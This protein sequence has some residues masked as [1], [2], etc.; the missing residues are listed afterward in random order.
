MIRELEL[1]IEQLLENISLEHRDLLK[2]SLYKAI[3]T[4]EIAHLYIS[5]TIRSPDFKIIIDTA[6]K[7]PSAIAAYVS[8]SN[9][10]IIFK[11]AN[12]WKVADSSDVSR[13]LLHEFAHG[14]FAVLHAPGG[15]PH[16][17]R[18]DE[19]TLLARPLAPLGKRKPVYNEL[20]QALNYDLQVLVKTL[21][22]FLTDRANFDKQHPELSEY[23]EELSERYVPKTETRASSE[24]QPGENCETK[25]EDVLKELK[26]FG[27]ATQI[28][29]GY[30]WIVKSLYEPRS[31]SCGFLD[32][33]GDTKWDIVTRKLFEL[34]WYITSELLS[35]NRF[36][37]YRSQ[38]LNWYIQDDPLRYQSFRNEIQL[39]AAELGFG[40]WMARIS[41]IGPFLQ[42]LQRT[43]RMLA[44][45]Y[46]THARAENFRREAFNDAINLSPRIREGYLK[47]AA[48]EYPAKTPEEIIKEIYKHQKM[49]KTLS[50]DVLEPDSARGMQQFIE[51]AN[52]KQINFCA[53]FYALCMA[54]N[55]FLSVGQLL[56]DTFIPLA[57]ETENDPVIASNSALEEN[58][59]WNT[60]QI[61]L[62]TGAVALS[63]VCTYLF[64]NRKNAN[65]T[66]Q[67]DPINPKMRRQ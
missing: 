16:K 50:L 39:A 40:E 14:Y 53:R 42:L 38:Y 33:V 62:T 31:G 65:D 63:L 29:G 47:V 25:Y 34:Y 44:T 32:H 24:L 11:N 46:E 3:S 17:H 45:D 59:G 35:Q 66:Q 18:R 22:F 60:G 41:E 23:L 2:Q 30:P 67:P 12:Y 61:V 7:T 28:I 51:D 56:L 43:N 26:N 21:T 36:D 9:A 37:S 6:T 49:S 19:R 54:G 58:E 48:L 20:V 52:A 64:W 10:L 55:S 8:D 5:Y 4:S 57:I 15:A 13:I 1:L 27:E